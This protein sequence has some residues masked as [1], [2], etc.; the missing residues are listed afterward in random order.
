MSDALIR[1]AS[2]ACINFPSL[3]RAFSRF[4][5]TFAAFS[6]SSANRDYDNDDNDNNDDNDDNGDIDDNDN[7]DYDKRTT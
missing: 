1:S 2:N 5:I 7:N 3:S 6:F 4:S